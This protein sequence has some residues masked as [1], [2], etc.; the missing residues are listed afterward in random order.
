MT[1]L[2]SRIA[3]R[4]SLRWRGNDAFLF[5]STMRS[6]TN[7]PSIEEITFSLRGSSERRRTYS[8]DHTENE[9]SPF[10]SSALDLPLIIFA[11][12]FMIMADFSSIISLDMGLGECFSSA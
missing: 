4:I 5:I 7:M 9:L 6:E 2:D 3:D 11:R 10:L 8:R 12:D 1:H